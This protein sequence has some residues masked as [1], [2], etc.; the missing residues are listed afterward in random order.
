MQLG[1]L[2]GISLLLGTGI[3]GDPALEFMHFDGYSILVD[4]SRDYEFISREE[5]LRHEELKYGTSINFKACLICPGSDLHRLDGGRGLYWDSRVHAEG[6][7]SQYRWVGWEFQI[8]LDLTPDGRLQ[9]FHKHHSQHF[10]DREAIGSAGPFPLHD[11]V[12]FRIHFIH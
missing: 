2:I 4:R 5:E 12:G 1:L 6:S 3:Y 11:S 9:A 7:E 10:M 8:Q